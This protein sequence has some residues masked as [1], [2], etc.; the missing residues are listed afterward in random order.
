VRVRRILCA[1]CWGGWLLAAIRV[2][3]AAAAGQ[4]TDPFEKLNVHQGF[5]SVPVDPL[6]RARPTVGWVD[7]ELTAGTDGRYKLQN[8]TSHAGDLRSQWHGS[9]VFENNERS[10]AWQNIKQGDLRVQLSH[11]RGDQFFANFRGSADLQVVGSGVLFKPTR[12]LAIQGFAQETIQLRR[13]GRNRTSYSRLQ[14]TLRPAPHWDLQPTVYRYDVRTTTYQGWTGVNLFVRY[15]QAN[16]RITH[17]GRRSDRYELAYSKRRGRWEGR[18]GAQWAR[19]M[20]TPRRRLL[21]GG[22]QHDNVGLDVFRGTNQLAVLVQWGPLVVGQSW[23]LQGRQRVLGV[24]RFSFWITETPRGER[25]VGVGVAFR[26][27]LRRFA[28]RVTGWNSYAPI[29]QSTVETPH[30]RW[31]GFGSRL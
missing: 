25:D 31:P 17:E 15:R 19:W 2:L 12:T 20:S 8:T 27:L 30:I 16:V 6:V 23:T 22:L 5:P 1:L 28:K 11:P 10:R 9:L 18:T 4:D 3:P 7:G 24:Q 14:L 26:G 13:G 29:H 21:H